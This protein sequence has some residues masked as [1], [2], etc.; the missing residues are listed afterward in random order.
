MSLTHKLVTTRLIFAGAFHFGQFTDPVGAIPPWLPQTLG[1]RSKVKC[2]HFCCGIW[3]R[4]F[5]L[6]FPSNGSPDPKGCLNPI[7]AP[8]APLH[9]CETRVWG[10]DRTLNPANPLTHHPATWGIPQSL[11]LFPAVSPPPTSPAA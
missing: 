1:D 8:P 10:V 3:A 2:S 4:D 11:P 6:W 5:N 7:A 9:G